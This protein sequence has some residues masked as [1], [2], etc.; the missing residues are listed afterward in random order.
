MV[1]CIYDDLYRQRNLFINKCM[2]A[3][4]CLAYSKILLLRLTFH[5]KSHDF[6]D[7]CAY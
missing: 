6:Y 5:D 4:K 1:S 3:L 2:V 7:A